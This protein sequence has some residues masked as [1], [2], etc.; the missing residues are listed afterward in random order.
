MKVKKFLVLMVMVLA[1]AALTRAGQNTPATPVENILDIVA[2]VAIVTATTQTIKKG[3]EALLKKA[4]MPAVAF[5]LSI[6]VAFFTV[7]IK[8]LQVGHPFNAALF[9]IFIQVVIYSSGTF[10]MVKKLGEAAKPK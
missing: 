8:A 5:G 10:L 3:L 2:L 9:F 4:L 7:A 6:C 1:F